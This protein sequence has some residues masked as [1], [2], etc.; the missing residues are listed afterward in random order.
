MLFRSTHL[1]VITTTAA[2]NHYPP[3]QL[4]AQ[5]SVLN[6]IYAP[7]QISFTT[8]S[9]DYTVNDEWASCHIGPCEETYKGALRRGSYAD[10]NLYFLSDLAR[11]MNI[12]CFTTLP[13]SAPNEQ[14]LILD[15]V[16]VLADSMPGG[17]VSHTAEL[18]AF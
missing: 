3:S 15:G 10:L 13:L 17:S 9:I 1:H 16:A 7:S 12:L 5:T 11:G 4:A 18:Q 14:E 6:E 8:I 2:K